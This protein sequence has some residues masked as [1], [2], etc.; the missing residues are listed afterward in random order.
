MAGPARFLD[1]KRPIHNVLREGLA[2]FTAP[3]RSIEIARAPSLPPA[4]RWYALEPLLRAS[5]VGGDYQAFVDLS[6]LM[7][8]VQRGLESQAAAWWEGPEVLSRWREFVPIARK[9]AHD[10]GDAESLMTVGYFFYPRRFQDLTAAI[11]FCRSFFPWY[12]TEHRHAGIAMLTPDDVHHHR[13]HS[14]LEQRERTLQAAWT[15]HPERFVRG[16][17]QPDRRDPSCAKRPCA[18]VSSGRVPADH[19]ASPG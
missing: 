9:L 6:D 16:V 19:A 2:R 10:A 12:N 4:L 8:E 11:A 3:E 5:L 15:H 14:V 18:P 1:A 7:T 17:P 13:A